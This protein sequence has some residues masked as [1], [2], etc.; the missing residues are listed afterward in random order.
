MSENISFK[1]DEI[2]P[3][4][5]QLSKIF[6]YVSLMDVAANKKFVISEN[7]ELKTVSVSEEAN[8][9][10]SIT[11]RALKEK[12]QINKFEFLKQNIFFV[13]A[14]YILIEGKEFVLESVSMINNDSL[15]KD[16]GKNDFIR[17][18]NEYSDENYR[19]PLTTCYNRR[20]Y[21]DQKQ[22]L[23]K[24]TAIARVDLDLFR[25]IKETYGPMVADAALKTLGVT[26]QKCV[27]KTDSIIYLEDEKFLI[28]FYGMKQPVLKGKLEEIR[29]EIQRT[30]I[31]QH[32]AVKLSISIGGYFAEKISINDIPKAQKLLD[33]ARLHL[34]YVVVN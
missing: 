27:R 26:M 17:L 32:P 4:L 24:A 1:K 21:D 25:Q 10:D 7:G 28:F 33:E 12:T 16:F 3:F 23:Q 5:K 9:P 15:F 18:F 19:D 22:S 11:K 2:I 30:V 20:Y 34:N 6:T 29:A 8:S 14:K 31:P 13:T